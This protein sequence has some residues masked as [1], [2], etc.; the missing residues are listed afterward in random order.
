MSAPSFARA[1]LLP[2]TGRRVNDHRDR[3]ARNGES[4]NGEPWETAL[5][6]PLADNT[7]WTVDIAAAAPWHRD[8]AAMLSAAETERAARF[9]R[10][11]DRDRFVV[12][13]AALRLIL[14]R[15]LDAD[16]AALAFTEGPVGKP[17]LAEPWRGRLH[18]N[19]SHSGGRALVGLSPSAPIGVDVE[20]LRP[21]PDAARVARSYFAPDEAAALAALPDEAREGAFMA[22]WTCKEA[23]VKALGTGLSMPLDR[24]SVS[25][26]PAPARILSARGGRLDP[27]A[28]T[29]MRLEPGAGTLGAV[30]IAEP[31][32]NLL[33]RTLATGWPDRIA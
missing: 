20:A 32:A 33:L 31:G 30:A 23:V 25:L 27:S 15:A 11:E 14:G 8:C 24:F 3:E 6:G 26:P 29:L 1:R 2:A 28:F 7:V 5:P 4:W 21:M 12:S 17:D 18:F 16:P 9:R 19:L 22:V 13:H 10:P